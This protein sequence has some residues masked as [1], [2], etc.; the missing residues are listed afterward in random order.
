MKDNKVVSIR[1]TLLGI[2]ILPALIIGVVLAILSVNK[3]DKGMEEEVLNGLH[4]TCVAA[5]A[6]F[7]CMAE[8][9]FS[10]EVSVK[11]NDEI[12]WQFWSILNILFTLIVLKLFN[13]VKNT[14][15]KTLYYNYLK[16][17][18]LSQ[19]RNYKDYINAALDNE[20]V[21]EKETS[22]FMGLKDVSSISSSGESARKSRIWE[23]INAAGNLST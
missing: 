17:N 13:S 14:L 21:N 15:T 2:A 1:W 22:G 4:Q 11:S 23:K 3:M 9:D 18:K 12:L 19:I 6:G 10:Q 7:D 20:E 5:R 16:V 8:G